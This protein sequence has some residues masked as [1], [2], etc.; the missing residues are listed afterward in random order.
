MVEQY[1]AMLF[2]VMVSVP[3]GNG[4]MFCAGIPVLVVP[5][6]AYNDMVLLLI[7][8]NYLELI[9]HDFLNPINSM[10]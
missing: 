2:C 3:V 5:D 1:H 10:C 9:L 4:K 8:M 6:T 7:R